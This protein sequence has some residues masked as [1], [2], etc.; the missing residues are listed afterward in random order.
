M[1]SFP[2]QH[3][4][5]LVG[6]GAAVADRRPGE[7]ASAVDVAIV[8]SGYTGVLAA[9]HLAQ[10]GMSVAVFDSHEIGIGASS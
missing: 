3:E 8:G 10:G 9:L 5:Y 7:P 4:L 6:C 2:M 1:T